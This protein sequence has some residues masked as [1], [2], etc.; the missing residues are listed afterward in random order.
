MSVPGSMTPEY[1]EKGLQ[2]IY[3]KTDEDMKEK[4]REVV[5]LDVPE[6]KMETGVVS[7]LG[8]VC[9]IRVVYGVTKEEFMVHDL[10]L[11]EVEEKCRNWSEKVSR[12]KQILLQSQ[13]LYR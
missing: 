5:P 7:V 1:F 12:G 9:T 6:E 13:K 10:S 8:E 4:G 2:N 3:K 11:S